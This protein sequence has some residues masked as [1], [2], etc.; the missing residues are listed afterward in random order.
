MIPSMRA[1]ERRYQASLTFCKAEV[2][3]YDRPLF[4]TIAFQ[5]DVEHPPIYAAAALCHVFLAIVERT[6]T[7]LAG[8]IALH[9]WEE[10]FEKLFNGAGI[11]LKGGSGSGGHPI[12]TVMERHVHLHKVWV[13]A[14]RHCLEACREALYAHLAGEDSSEGTDVDP[15]RFRLVHCVFSHMLRLMWEVS[16]GT[17]AGEHS[18]YDQDVACLVEELAWCYTECRPF[19]ASDLKRFPDSPSAVRADRLYDAVDRVLAQIDRLPKDRRRPFMLSHLFVNAVDRVR[20][21]R[22]PYPGGPRMIVT[23]WRGARSWSG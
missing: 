3:R 7:P 21:G 1:A 6:S 10:Q 8:E 17:Q 5:R 19:A 11:K 13:D 15:P 20:F 2:K 23:L 18:I 12:L 22:S 9:W 16:R 4:F 14:M